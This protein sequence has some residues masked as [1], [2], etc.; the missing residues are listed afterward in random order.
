[1]QAERVD[2]NE[3]TNELNI[4]K[5]GIE[6]WYNR[7]DNYY[8]QADK[9]FSEAQYELGLQQLDLYFWHTIFP[10]CKIIESY[11][12]GL[13]KLWYLEKAGQYTQRLA[14]CER[15]NFQINIDSKEFSLLVD[16]FVSDIDEEHD[17]FLY[18]SKKYY[19]LSVKGEM[20]SHI[21]YLDNQ[22]YLYLDMIS[23]YFLKKNV[24]ET[25]DKKYFDSWL[26]WDIKDFPLFLHLFTEEFESKINSTDLTYYYNEILKYEPY[27]YYF[28]NNSGSSYLS[29][30]QYAY[31]KLA[32]QKENTEIRLYYELMAYD[33]FL[34][35][36]DV[37]DDESIVKE[38]KDSNI[39]DIYATIFQI[40][41]FSPTLNDSFF[42]ILKE[43]FW[44]NVN[45]II[46]L[47]NDIVLDY[48]PDK[49]IKLANLYWWLQIK[50]QWEINNSITKILWNIISNDMDRCN[51]VN[52]VF[53]E[54]SI[55]IIFNCSEKQI[56]INVKVENN[57]N[58]KL[59]DIDNQL[60]HD[61]AK[62]VL[63]KKKIDSETL[64]FIITL[65]IFFIIVAL[66][67]Y[68]FFMNKW[69]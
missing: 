26:K 28:S 46:L 58:T 47:I 68:V 31:Q 32:L 1:M 18:L 3:L 48:A 55:N 62:T 67:V 23:W 9:H 59:I 43:M 7:Y 57:E 45:E 53:L 63:N 37:L 64:L 60:E 38:L 5:I 41:E 50:N 40:I 25:F 13:L 51:R 20:H 52:Q 15:E 22:Y 6:Y 14:L 69:K 16:K 39:L 27:V 2:F 61:N 24:S 17:D 11:R 35:R 65:I 21:K 4:E 19:L 66:I 42:P 36:L 8:N 12:D 49:I 30:H 54:N 10:N 44:D 34:N 33:E 56:N 29:S